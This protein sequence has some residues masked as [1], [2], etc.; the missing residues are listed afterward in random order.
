[1]DISWQLMG[2]TSPSLPPFQILF[3]H[4]PYESCCCKQSDLAKMQLKQAFYLF[5]YFLI[6]VN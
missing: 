2:P 6:N 5:I 3:V 4:L 1:M